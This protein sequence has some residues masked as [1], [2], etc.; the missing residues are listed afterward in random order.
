MYE[1]LLSFITAFI[2]SYFIIPSVIN[3]AHAKHLC[4]EPGERRSHVVSTPSL[5]GVAIF[6]GLMFSMIFWMPFD[7][8]GQLQYTLCAFIII[9]LIGVKDDIIPISPYK[10]LLGELMAAGIIV[11]K[12]GVKITSLH[13]MFGIY[14]IPEWFSVLLTIFTII[15]I[16]NSFNLIDGINGLSGSLTTLISLSFGSWFFYVGNNPMTP[17]EVANTCIGLSIMAF[18]L[19]GAIVAFLK[20]NFT[21]ATIFMGDTGALLLGLICSILVVKFI[22]INQL[23]VGQNPLAIK[24]SPAVAI[25]ILILPLFDTLRVFTIRILRGRSPF[26][27]DRLHIHHLLVDFGFTHMQATGVLIAVT[28]FFIIFVL[29]LQNIGTFKLLFLIIALA[30]LLSYFLQRLVEKKVALKAKQLNNP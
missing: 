19:A 16:I 9:F 24:A 8:F 15:V 10:K 11:L 29:T 18:S 27:P 17:Y 21:P 23:L 4:D 5:G 25:G 28:S 20:Y 1:V 13:G 26:S 12:S 3:V 14:E 2:P 7:V 30:T 6:A 22:E